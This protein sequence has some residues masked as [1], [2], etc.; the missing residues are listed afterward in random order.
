MIPV[1][2][3]GTETRQI[4]DVIEM[5]SNLGMMLR[6]N[7]WLKKWIR[8]LLMLWHRMLQYMQIEEHS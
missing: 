1:P 8:S 7:R 3:F 5:L 2:T 4:L 6:E